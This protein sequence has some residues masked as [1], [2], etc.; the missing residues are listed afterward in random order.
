MTAGDTITQFYTYEYD[1]HRNVINE[2]QYSYIFVEGTGPELIR[3]TAYAYDDK[4][5][6][7]TIFKETGN[8]GLYSNTNNIVE[9]SNSKLWVKPVTIFI[10]HGFLFHVSNHGFC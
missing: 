2:K 9:N 1:D 7:F 3:E 5:N 4:N 8:P 6:P 10:A